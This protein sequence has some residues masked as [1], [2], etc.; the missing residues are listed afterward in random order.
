[1]ASTGNDI[2]IEVNNLSREYKMA[3][4]FLQRRRH[5]T[6]AL[7]HVSF[8]IPRG[9]LFGIIGP[10]G[11]GKT[12]LMKILCTLLLPT[13]GSVTVL[14]LNVASQEKYIRKR[15]NAVFGGDRGLYTRLSGEDNLKYFADIYLVPRKT[16]ARRVP[17]L[18]EL[19]GLKGREKERV[20]GYS[21]G[22]KQRLHIAKAL[23]NDPEILLLDEPTIGLDPNISRDLRA[24]IQHLQQQKKTIL[25]TS[26]YM[27]E[28]DT[29][30][31]RVAMINKGNLL[32]IDTPF[33]L[34]RYVAGLFIVEAQVP[35]WSQGEM[36]AEQVKM[37]PDVENVEVKSAFE[38]SQISVRTAAPE[39]VSAL[40][41]EHIAHIDGGY[42]VTREP[43]LEDAYMKLIGGQI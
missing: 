30:C 32:T 9:E 29:L 43:S 18:L 20:E 28:I 22:M 21:R 42:V 12:S 41:K 39:R 8:S 23:I 25:L 2:V 33:N 36:L 24:L 19:V 34:K 40:L 1:M 5:S 37:L 31:N 10:N 4:G 6:L 13:A 27:H 38:H 7:N 17:E 26:H 16:A 11:A 35:F 3:A 15:I 14:G